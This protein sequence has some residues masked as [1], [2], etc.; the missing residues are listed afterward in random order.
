[1]KL[2]TDLSAR[3][4]ESGTRPTIALRAFQSATNRFV[5]RI[6]K[7]TT[8]VRFCSLVCVCVCF[9]GC[10]RSISVGIRC[11]KKS[12]PPKLPSGRGQAFAFEKL[13]SQCV[14]WCGWFFFYCRCAHP[15]SLSNSSPHFLAAQIFAARRHWRCVG[16]V[17]RGHCQSRPRQASWKNQLASANGGS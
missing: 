14:D 6:S 10:M 11:C 12:P 1:M 8:L 7:C 3:C 2:T 9:S 4:S 13:E 17:A 5:S 16:N 15:R